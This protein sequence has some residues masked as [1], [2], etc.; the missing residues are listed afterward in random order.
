MPTDPWSGSRYPASTAAPNVAQ[1]IQNAVNDLAD[2][3]TAV[4]A[5]AAARDTA[6]TNWKNAGNAAFSGMQAFT[7]SDGRYWRYDTASSSW[8]YNGGNPPPIVLCTIFGGWNGTAGKSPAVYK[9]SSG[10]VH[11]I[12]TV[13]PQ[14]TYNPN[15]GLTHTAI[16]LPTGYRPSS[17]INITI[18][19]GGP[20]LQ[21][22]IDT[23]G[24]LSIVAG[25]ASSI[26]AGTDHHLSATTPFHPGYTGGVLA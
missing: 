1:D 15:D 17:L 23:N 12:G 11:L 3:A 25:T 22:A 18:A 2:N 8:L 21:G 5:T 4:F 26:N 9:D 14:T 6:F 7:T 19:A 13:N 16:T 20:V 10:L 24:V